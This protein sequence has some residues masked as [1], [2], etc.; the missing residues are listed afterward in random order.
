MKVIISG[1][2]SRFL[3][4]R[5]IKT[6]YKGQGLSMVSLK[7]EYEIDSKDLYLYQEPIYLLIFYLCG[8]RD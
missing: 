6:N 3:S 2:Q 1:I 8:I 4:I 5:G 7:V